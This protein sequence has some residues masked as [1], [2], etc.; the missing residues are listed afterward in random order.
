VL[1]AGATTATGTAA[2]GAPISGGTV[3][4]SCGN[5]FTTSTTSA[6]DGRWTASV[7]GTALPCAVQITGGT[8]RGVSNTETFYSLARAASGSANTVA[9][10]TP[11]SD[12]ALAR[13]VISTVGVTLD[14]WFAGAT[15]A[16]R[17]QVA[18]ALS[19]AVNALT[20]ALTSAG[21]SLPVGFDPFSG[22]LT[23]GSAVDA[24]DQLLEAYQAALAE[25]GQSYA[26]A[27]SG[28]TGSGAVTAPP[29]SNPGGGGG[30]GGDTVPGTVNAA[31]VKSYTLVFRQGGGLDRK[32]TRL[33]SSHNSESRMPSSA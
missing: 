18:S 3:K 32:S 22:V 25:A 2:I 1:S 14:A 31:L 5:G 21:Y 19:V 10:L 9:H 15:D 24:Y 12:L 29:P 20:S 17:Q 16:Q 23:A 13:A 6:A 7:P 33:N 27:R 30:G 28:F 26:A 4:L 8:V 11:M